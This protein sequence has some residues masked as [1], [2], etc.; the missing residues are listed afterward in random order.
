[1][2][3]QRTVAERIAEQEIEMAI[4]RVKMEECTVKKQKILDKYLK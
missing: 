3:I 2:N 4:C 1:M